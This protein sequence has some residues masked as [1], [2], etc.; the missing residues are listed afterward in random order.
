MHD[1]VIRGGKVVD[2]SGA[3]A[4][5]ADVAIDNGRVT[6]AEGKAGAAKREM[7]ADGLL[8]TPGFVDVHTHYD[9]QVTW[10]P[11]L[12][13]TGWH[14]VTTVVMGNCGVGFAPAAPDRREWLI[15]I[16]E[17]VEDIPGSAL[18]EG[19]QWAW[20]SF[21]EYLDALDA[22]PRAL[23]FG[24]Q[25]PHS[26]VRAY[27]MQERGA[28]NEDPTD[29]DIAKMSA[30]VEEGLRAGAL[31]FSSSRTMLHRAKDGTPV[32]GTFAGHY[33]LINLGRACGRVG[34]GVFEIAT[35][36]GIG[37]ALG[38]FKDDID[39]MSHLSKETGLPVSF[40]L[41]QS[42]REPGEWKQ[43]MRWT[44]AAVAEGANLRLQVANRPAGMLLNFD[45]SMHPF[46]G[47]P[48]YKKLANLPLG[49]R[50]EALRRTEVREQ[51]FSEGTDLTGKFDRF[52]VHHFG[53]MYPLGD[54]PNYEPSPEESIAAIAER[55]GKQ[56][57]AVL[58]DFMLARDGGEFIYYPIINYADASFEP[59]REMMNHPQALLS[60]S[61]GGAHCGLICDASS[62]S[63]MLSYWVRDREKGERLGLEHAVHLQTQRTAEAYG[64]ADRG[65]LR[66]GYRADLNVIDLDALHLHAPEAAYD[67]PANGRRLVQRVDGYKATLKNGV[68]TYRDGEPTGALPGGLIRGPQSL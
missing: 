55:T 54:P 33:E 47:H 28:A 12:S 30:I 7:D 11:Y 10:D 66:P 36:F 57:E 1:M 59:I 34:H 15:G 23:D 68:P 24:T 6:S 17:A 64:L 3:A 43:I 18:A 56:V 48:T 65:V 40:T 46:M 58:L 49:E 16:M 37:G 60:L 8:V 45:A 2:G 19:I 4:R 35:D 50:V 5:T 53:N 39:W 26:A 13:P 38:R 42:D 51:L 52:F 9:G 20:E 21:P 67:L 41:A 32:P 25:V 22:L 14:G 63:F 62:P 31:G 61:D 44:E 29:E 27:V